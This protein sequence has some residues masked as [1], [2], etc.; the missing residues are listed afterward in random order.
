[1]F[2]HSKG[3]TNLDPD[4]ELLRGFCP[5]FFQLCIE[6][7]VRKKEEQ[8]LCIFLKSL[9]EYITVYGCMCVCPQMQ[10]HAL[11][12]FQTANLSCQ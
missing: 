4:F 5:L 11:F 8:D 10:I 6:F 9:Q 3:K 1:M 2:Y 7:S 12:C